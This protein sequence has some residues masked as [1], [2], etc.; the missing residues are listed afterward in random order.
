[1][2]ADD[3]RQ[4]SAGDRLPGRRPLGR[5]RRPVAARGRLRV[6]A[7]A[8]RQAAPRRRLRPSRDRRAAARRPRRAGGAGRVIA[9]RPLREDEYADWD[10]AH[11]AEYARG[12]VEHVG[13]S[14]RADADAK[15]ARDVAA[16]LPDG[17]ATPG[18]WIWVVE[19]DG[20]RSAASSVGVP[21]TAARG[22]TTSRST[23]R[24]R[25]RLRPGGDD[26]AR[27]RGAALGL[28]RAR[29]QR[30]GAATRSRAASTARSAGPRSRCTCASGSRTLD[31]VL[32]RDELPVERR[33]APPA[34][35]RAPARRAARSRRGRRRRSGSRARA[36]SAGSAPRARR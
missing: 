14:P 8:A 16:V 3:P 13:H 31:R 10:A 11:R 35:A 9:L 2:I 6:R 27:G 28:A 19:A 34:V 26:G 21:A 7:P 4:R 32:D 18:T 1:M 20:R 25:P 17:L 5:A 22:S 29:A 15:V 33:S 23:S 36:R 24:A 30:H 12:L